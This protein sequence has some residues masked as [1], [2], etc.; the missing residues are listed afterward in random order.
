M[1]GIQLAFTAAIVMAQ[2][3]F[4]QLKGEIIFN[5]HSSSFGF[6]EFGQK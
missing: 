5:F 1:S 2:G 3:K 4:C 6:G